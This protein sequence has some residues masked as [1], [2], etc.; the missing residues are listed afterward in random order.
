MVINRGA[1][2]CSD[3]KYSC[4]QVV[5][6]ILPEGAT[7][8]VWSPKEIAAGKPIVFRSGR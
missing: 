5:P 1:G 7:L 6:Q 8:T 4:A 2:V 3:A